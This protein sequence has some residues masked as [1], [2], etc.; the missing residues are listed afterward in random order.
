[1]EKKEQHVCGFDVVDRGSTVVSVKKIEKE[2][3]FYHKLAVSG[4]K[5]PHVLASF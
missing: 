5:L 2:L 3:Y 1:L 4:Y